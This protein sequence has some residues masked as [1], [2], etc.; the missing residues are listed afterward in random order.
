MLPGSWGGGRP[1]RGAD[2]DDDD[3]EI[4]VD[5]GD[6]TDG[7]TVEAERA[8][9][10]IDTSGRVAAAAEARGDDEVAAGVGAGVPACAADSETES[11][12]WTSGK[13]S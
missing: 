10:D 2:D 11:A 8:P 1:D 9:S 13:D 6:A 4:G 7:P 3:D 12:G 5:A